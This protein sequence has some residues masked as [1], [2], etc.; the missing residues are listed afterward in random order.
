MAFCVHELGT[1]MIR[2]QRADEVVPT[3]STYKLPL[4]LHIALLVEEGAL[5]WAQPFTLEDRHK[6]WGSGVLRD[7]SVGLTFPLRDLC[8]LMTALSDNTATDLLLDTL[9]LD[10][11]NRRLA[12]LGFEQ[13]RLLP[14]H[15]APGAG[16]RP[17]L[18][19]GVTTP[20]EMARLLRGI[21]LH[22]LCSSASSSVILGML[23][24]QH[25][26]SMIP[27]FLQ[28]DWIYSGKTGSNEDL[29]ADVGIVTDPQGRSFVLALYCQH[30]TTFD[31]SVESPGTLTLAH[32]ARRLLTSP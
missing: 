13:T 30:P 19:V 4:L 1:G 8:H 14:Q 15:A 16:G 24:A 7:L 3:A 20:A 21:V 26:R 18:A 6:S 5:S 2:A 27:R 11:V 9:G 28:P 10:G 23:G 22:E 31:W 32:L 29:R 12:G 17:P 25:D